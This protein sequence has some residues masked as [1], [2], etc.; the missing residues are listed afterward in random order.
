M[1]NRYDIAA[2]FADLPRTP[3]ELGTLADNLMTDLLDLE[4]RESDILD[5]SV[6]VGFAERKLDIAVTVCVHEP[7]AAIQIFLAGVQSTPHSVGIT[8]G[9]GDVTI[10]ATPRHSTVSYL[11]DR[12]GRR[13]DGMMPPEATAHADRD[14]A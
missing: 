5:P 3:G 10:R 9:G 12:V 6:G 13:R 7:L 4:E 2:T 14:A 1:T 8:T 11:L